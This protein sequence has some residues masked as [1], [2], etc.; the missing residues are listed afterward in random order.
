MAL[1]LIIDQDPETRLYQVLQIC[2]DDIADVLSEHATRQDANNAK[3]DL[4]RQESIN[5]A[6]ERHYQA[7][8]AYACGY[9]D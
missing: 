6:E 4:L 9:H 7:Q 5:A 2:R 1:H 3:R 8:Y